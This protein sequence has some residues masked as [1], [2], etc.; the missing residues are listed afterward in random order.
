MTVTST[1]ANSTPRSVN[2]PARPRPG[3]RILVAITLLSCSSLG[4]DLYKVIGERL[5]LLRLEG[6]LVVV[7]HDPV[8]EAL[9]HLGARLLDRLLDEGRVLALEDLVEVRAD[10]PV[11]ARVRERVAGA[12][13]GRGA[14]REDRLAV[15][16]RAAAG[17]AAAAA[18][19]GGLRLHVLHPLVEVGLGDDVGALAHDGVAEPAQLGA[20]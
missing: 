18:A 2:R 7:G 8:L 15:G 5:D 13:G 1:A 16:R 10:G 11:G 6:G 14:A 9:G 12:A 19:A 20:D 17:L 3:A 4:R